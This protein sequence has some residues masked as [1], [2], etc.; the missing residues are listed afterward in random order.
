M[1]QEHMLLGGVLLVVALTAVVVG[2]TVLFLLPGQGTPDAV[3]AGVHPTTSFAESTISVLEETSSTSTVAR[4]SG[5]TTTISAPRKLEIIL[6]EMEV[7][8]NDDLTITVASQGSPV[9]GV[10]L[11]VNGSGEYLTDSDGVAFIQYLDGGEYDVVARKEGFVEDAASFT[12]GSLRYG[13]SP[14]VKEQRT[15][16]ERRALIWDGKVVFIFY[17]RPNCPNCLRM[18]PWASD[19]VEQNRDCVAYEL[20]RIIYDG[21][22]D[23]LKE[24]FPD[25]TF[26]DTPVLVFDGPAGRSVSEGFASKQAMEA[27]LMAASDG[28][29]SII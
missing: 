4:S 5:E 17:D 9:A 1:R 12:V 22:R 24:L 18:K 10:L 14:A 19:I 25:Q 21:P 6:S 16:D 26:V 23:E 15:P 7:Y 2:I 8:K 3:N 11:T 29:C 27:R 20:L 13:L 28:R